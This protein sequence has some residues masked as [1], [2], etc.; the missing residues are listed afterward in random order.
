M[1]KF[2]EESLGKMARKKVRTIFGWSKEMKV[3]GLLSLKI[4]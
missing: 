2:L 4:I 3:M 1:L